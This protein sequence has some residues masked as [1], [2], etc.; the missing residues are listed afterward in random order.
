MFSCSEG[1]DV[2]DWIWRWCWLLTDDSV[3]DLSSQSF[4]TV[5]VAGR[6]YVDKQS[7]CTRRTPPGSTDT[8][9]VDTVSRWWCWHDAAAGNVARIQRE[10][11]QSGWLSTGSPSCRQPSP[12]CSFRQWQRLKLVTG[13]PDDHRWQQSYHPVAY[14]LTRTVVGKTAWIQTISQWAVVCDQVWLPISHGWR[15]HR[16]LQSVYRLFPVSWS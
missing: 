3:T 13:W 12:R 9:A 4:N 15:N 6:C 14:T 7:A 16:R 2:I 10:Y 8:I 5:S 11:H 1:D